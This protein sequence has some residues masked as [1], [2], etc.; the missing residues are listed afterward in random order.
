MEKF[1]RHVV[2]RI[3]GLAIIL[4]AATGVMWLNYNTYRI[5]YTDALQSN[6][7]SHR[8]GE[9]LMGLVLIVGVIFFLVVLAGIVV[10]GLCLM[11]FGANRDSSQEAITGDNDSN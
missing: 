10:A 1:L 7:T 6:I 8:A 4:L 9:I 3:G 2:A 5:A 11:F